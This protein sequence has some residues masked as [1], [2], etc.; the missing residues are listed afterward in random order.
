LSPDS[1]GPTA[2]EDTGPDSSDRPLLRVT[3]SL[4]T[5]LRRGLLR[6]LGFACERLA[7]LA[8]AGEMHDQKPYESAFWTIAATHT[9]LAK[10]GVTP[11]LTPQSIKLSTADHPLVVYEALKAELELASVRRESQADEGLPE[12]GDTTSALE[13]VVGALRVHLSRS[14]SARRE[15][16]LSGAAARDPRIIAS[17]TRGRVDSV[18][19]SSPVRAAI[20]QFAHLTAIALASVLHQD[21]DIAV[22][23]EGLDYSRLR[24]ALDEPEGAPQVVLLD[25]DSAISA[26]INGLRERAPGLGIVVITHGATAGSRMLRSR[27]EMRAGL[28]CL[29]TN[30]SGPDICA[31]VRMA[32]NPDPRSGIERLTTREREV[33]ALLVRGERTAHIARSLGISPETVQTHVKSIY[34]KLNVRSRAEL[35]VHVHGVGV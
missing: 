21:R 16:E 20:G 22:V 11:S 13:P 30:T 26:V 2:G 29:S 17:R 18:S 4:A 23:G 14:A 25:E 10:V 12:S 24:R 6:E 1:G 32:A 35:A 8:L 33:I 27:L 28:S 19:E 31:A 3:P 9:V 34:R 5:P 15:A 7:Q